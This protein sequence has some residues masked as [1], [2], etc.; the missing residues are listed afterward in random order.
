LHILLASSKRDNIEKAEIPS[1]DSRASVETSLR[2]MG[3]AEDCTRR[4]TERTGASLCNSLGK[5]RVV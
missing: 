1:E 4:E 5:V 3:A 2:I